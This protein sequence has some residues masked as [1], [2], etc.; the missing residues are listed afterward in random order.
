M[1]VSVKELCELMNV[2]YDRAVVEA[3]ARVSNEEED[4][5]ESDSSQTAANEDSLEHNPENDP[6]YTPVNEG[7]I[8]NRGRSGKRANPDTWKGNIQKRKRMR[9]QSYLG[10]KKNEFVIK[11]ERKM[12]G[13]C[14]AVSCQKSSKLHC[15]EI[16]EGKREDIFKYFWEKLEWKERRMYVKTLLEVSDV[17]R[18]RTEAVQSRRSSSLFCC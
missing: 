8:E 4:S 16:D 10:W 7:A 6:D 15:S 13:R 5:L 17:K 1:S 3:I 2:S 9:G 14:Q 12:G 11:E 18:R